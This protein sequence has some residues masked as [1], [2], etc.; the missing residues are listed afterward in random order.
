VT[1]LEGTDGRNGSRS[2]QRVDR[3]AVQA[4][5]AERDL[6]TGRLRVPAGGECSRRSGE[7]GD[8]EK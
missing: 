6:E 4:L 7:C 1:P 2:C 5:G 8:R 3:P